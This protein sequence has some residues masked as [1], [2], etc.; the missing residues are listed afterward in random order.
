MELGC[1]GVSLLCSRVP[2]LHDKQCANGCLS[3]GLV[4]STYLENTISEPY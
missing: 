3:Q 2:E 1:P 4:K